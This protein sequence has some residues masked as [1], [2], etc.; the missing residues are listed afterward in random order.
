MHGAHKSRNVLHG[1]KHPQYKSGAFTKE[2]KK[3]AKKATLRLRVLEQIGWHLKMF[4][5]ARTRGK[6]PDGFLQFDLNDPEQ[7]CRAILM[8]LV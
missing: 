1:K 5:G 4:E 2:S 7:M 6:R 8:T 3:I